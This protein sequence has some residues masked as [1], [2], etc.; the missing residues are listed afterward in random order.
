MRHIVRFVKPCLSGVGKGLGDWSYMIVDG[1]YN[2]QKL[3]LLLYTSR[4]LAVNFAAFAEMERHL[5]G[6][7]RR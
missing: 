3:A 7:Q 4:V 2:N 6:M 5:W 1:F